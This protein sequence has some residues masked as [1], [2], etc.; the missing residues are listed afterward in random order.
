MKIFSIIKIFDDLNYEN[1]L[2]S[3]MEAKALNYRIQ[4]LHK[5]PQ[6]ISIC[7]LQYIKTLLSHTRALIKILHENIR[8][9]GLT[10]H[11][12]LKTCYHNLQSSRGI[13]CISF[14]FVF[15]SCNIFQRFNFM[16]FWYLNEYFKMSV[17]YKVEYGTKR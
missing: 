3:C 12:I 14:T 10:V 7:L 5:I 4:K 13:F 1:V 17:G 9:N 16:A 6:S 11:L 15:N 8:L 2:I